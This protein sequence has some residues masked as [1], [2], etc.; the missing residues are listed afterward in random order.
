M[1]NTKKNKKSTNQIQ[2]KISKFLIKFSKKISNKKRKKI[3]QLKSK[4]RLQFVTIYNI[5]NYN[6]IFW[7]KSWNNNIKK[8]YKALE[9]AKGLQILSFLKSY[10]AH[11]KILRKNIKVLFFIPNSEVLT[12]IKKVLA[13]IDKYLNIT[14]AVNF[15]EL[16]N[17][18]EKIDLIII[19]NFANSLK[20]GAILRKVSFDKKVSNIINISSTIFNANYK[21]GILNLTYDLTNLRRCVFLICFLNNLFKDNN[22][23]TKKRILEFRKE[24][25][26]SNQNRK[27][28]LES[29][30]N[31]YKRNLKKNNYY[32]ST[33]TLN[34]SKNHKS[35]PF[36]KNIKE[37]ASKKKI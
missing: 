7:L 26:T 16:T 3:K 12:I 8:S 29:F 35:K 22:L 2:N 17:I 1:K 9:L 15:I 32:N 37:N 5:L 6:Q 24:V 14:L 11:L 4:N 21:T 19:F 10:I 27:I 33:K 36:N 13:K 18:K 20:S 23:L 31:L 28:F 25:K 30:S 34:I